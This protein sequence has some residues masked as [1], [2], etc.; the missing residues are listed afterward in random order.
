MDAE[1]ELVKEFL[2]RYGS[3]YAPQLVLLMALSAM[4]V[5]RREM[6]CNHCYAEETKD[7]EDDDAVTTDEGIRSD[8]EQGWNG[9][10]RAP[11]S[12]QWNNVETEKL[13]EGMGLY[14]SGAALSP[15]LEVF[16]QNAERA[17]RGLALAEDRFLQH[18]EK[19]RSG[20]LSKNEN[21]ARGCARRRIAADPIASCIHSKDKF[22]D[23]R[24]QREGRDAAAA[25]AAADFSKDPNIWSETVPSDA[26]VHI[27]R[28][29]RFFAVPRGS[30]SDFRC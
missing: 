18:T 11:S 30:L 2:C 5:Y 15:L 20:P 21:G 19:I 16:L 22:V 14:A 25:G 24:Q 13:L 28:F 3:L 29:M 27:V 4:T 26:Q 10:R 6:S 17:R 23:Q 12:L 7:G 9:P 1:L 8:G